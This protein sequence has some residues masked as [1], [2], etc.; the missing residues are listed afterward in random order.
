MNKIIKILPMIISYIISTIIFIQLN[1]KWIWFEK[2]V[3]KI[4]MGYK[5]QLVVCLMGLIFVISII[6]SDSSKNILLILNGSIVAFILFILY[7]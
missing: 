4:K 6:L 7:C 2:I 5:W 3:K 1:K